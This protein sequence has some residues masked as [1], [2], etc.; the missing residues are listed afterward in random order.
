M[1][2]IR[3]RPLGRILAQ[4]IEEALA[5]HLPDLPPAIR[6]AIQAEAGQLCKQKLEACSRS[7]RAMRKTS[8]E[9]EIAEERRIAEAQRDEA[10][11]ELAE[12]VGRVG[13]G[14]VPPQ[15]VEMYER[16]IAKLTRSLERL[17]HEL[18]GIG[19]REIEGGLSSIYRVVQGLSQS[20]PFRDAKKDMLR[21]IFEANVRDFGRAPAA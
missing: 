1:Q 6:R 4:S 19:D 17:E 7:V 16:R 20:D 18:S 12:L 14:Q 13:K 15:A 3:R 10:M 2:V 9:D 5:L 8:F 21:D 11:R